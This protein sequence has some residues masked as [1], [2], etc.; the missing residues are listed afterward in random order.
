MAG[1]TSSTFSQKIVR[2][3]SLFMDEAM[4]DSA[5]M[6]FSYSNVMEDMHSVWNMTYATF[7]ELILLPSS[8]Y[9]LSLNWQIFTT[10][11]F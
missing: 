3:Y 4:Y 8:G 2:V 11:L 10:H 1:E 6:F 7:R 9:M 5:T